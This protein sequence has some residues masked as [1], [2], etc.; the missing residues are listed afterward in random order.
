MS[1]REGESITTSELITQLRDILKPSGDDLTIL[2]GRSDDK[3]SQ[4]VRNLKAHDTFERYGFAKYKDGRFALVKKGCDYLRENMNVI[5]YLLINDFKW[6]D[7]KEGLQKVHQIT[8]DEKRKIDVFDENVII[9][10]GLK[11]ITQTKVYERS[12]K[13]RD[14][15]INH[16]TI[17]GEIFCD[18]CNFNYKRFYGVEIG[19]GFIEIHHLKPVFKL[20]GQS[21]EQTIAEAI[22]NVVPVCS[23][24]HRMI[25][26]Y[27][28]KPIEIDFLKAQ[29]AING[30][31][32]R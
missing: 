29:I 19:K 18:A 14:A 21:L 17:N 8:A 24:C 9:Q 31:Y 22:R 10:E 12:R 23:N 30:V 25:H 32:S 3:F 4:I 5:R 6:P 7:L 20:G 1:I 16:F 27:I 2:A 28:T 13:L 26:R 15:A 11:K